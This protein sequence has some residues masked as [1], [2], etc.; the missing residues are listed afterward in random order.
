[1]EAFRL[2]NNSGH[3]KYLGGAFFTKWISFASART[4]I[5]AEEVAPILDK[6]VRDWINKHTR[7][8]MPVDLSTTSTDESPSRFASIATPN[9]LVAAVR[10]S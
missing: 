8:T 5:D 9:A 10:A 3:I 6:R 7:T 2:L 1:V 4:S